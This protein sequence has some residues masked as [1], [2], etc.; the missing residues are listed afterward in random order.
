[1][2]TIHAYL[3]SL[4]WKTGDPPPVVGLEL[5]FHGNDEEESIAP[6]Q[7]GE[8]RPPVAVLFAK[9]KA[10]AA[11]D[12]VSDVFVGLHWDWNDPDYAD[13]VPPA[14]TVFIVTSESMT[15]VAEWLVDMHA[16]GVVQ[17]WPHGRPGNA[18]TLLPGHSV[19][20]VS[21]D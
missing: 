16:D 9:F 15:Q 3:Q 21:W 10:I 8:G 12:N 20:W 19:Y 13:T 18:P 6:N 5:F 14:D 17:G 7:W 2:E 1:M 4:N 11:R